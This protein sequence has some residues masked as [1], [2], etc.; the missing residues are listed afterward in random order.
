[1]SLGLS[2]TLQLNPKAAI[3]KL[4]PVPVYQFVVGVTVISTLFADTWVKVTVA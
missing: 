2:A 3:P 4:A 1:M